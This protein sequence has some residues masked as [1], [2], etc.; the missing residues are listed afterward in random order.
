MRSASEAGPC[1]C[2]GQRSW[3]YLFSERGHDLGV[4]AECGLHYIADMPD[5]RQRLQPEL[6]SAQWSQAEQRRR[7]ELQHY[8]DLVARH[9]PSGRWL[10]VGCGTGG[11]MRLIDERGIAVEGLEL[12]ADRRKLAAQVGTV[13]DEPLEDLSLPEARYAAVTLVNVFSHVISPMTTL[14]EI[15]RI[16]MPGGVVLLHTGEIGPGAKRKHHRTWLLG[17]HL[18]FLGTSTI[19]RYAERV[20]LRIVERERVWQPEALYRQRLMLPSGDPRKDAIKKALRTPGL[21]PAFSWVASRTWQRGNPMW[22]SSIVLARARESAESRCRQN[23][24]VR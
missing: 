13:Y 12:S 5:P 20:G 4:C 11:L 21:L 23:S 8:I 14:H 7:T 18:M 3:T 2:C 22:E 1:D 16:L 6:T 9:A 19:E 17:E 15:R 24:S 10:D